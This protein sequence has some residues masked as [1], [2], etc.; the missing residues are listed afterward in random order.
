[1]GMQELLTAAPA[2]G[3]PAGAIITFFFCPYTGSFRKNG[4]RKMGFMGTK[5]HEKLNFSAFFSREYATNLRSGA[6]RSVTITL[7]HPEKVAPPV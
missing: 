2:E 4:K 6:T 5:F 3:E 1:M 7:W